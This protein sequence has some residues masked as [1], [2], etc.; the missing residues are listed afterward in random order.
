M[1]SPPPQPSQEAT[2]INQ[3]AAPT[4][5]PHSHLN[6][7]LH[8]RI[9]ITPVSYM[10]FSPPVDSVASRP[11]AKKLLVANRNEI[12]IRVFRAATELGLRTVAIY[13]QEDRLSIHRF[14][15][16]EAYLIG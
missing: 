8:G 2:K 10:N 9:A 1:E 6:L 3:A 15:A 12:A 4:K 16:D 11:A 14:K 7:E 5:S 13:A